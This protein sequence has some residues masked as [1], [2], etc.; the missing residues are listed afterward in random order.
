MARVKRA[1]GAHKKRRKV[2]K[3]AKGYYGSKSKQ[4]RAAN[5]QVLRSMAFAYVGRRLRKR[6]FRRLW[7]IRINAAARIHG[8]SY[9]QLMGGLKKAG[10]EIDRKVM[11]DLAVNDI[12]SFAKL[13]EVA[14]G[15]MIA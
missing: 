8:M 4:Y 3:L 14:R 10:V 13:V 7:I 5:Q 15:A 1:V 2:F 6:D 9:S 12:A 11:A